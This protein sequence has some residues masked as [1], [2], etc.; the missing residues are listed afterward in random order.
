VVHVTV[1]VVLIFGEPPLPPEGESDFEWY[2]G[3]G[4]IVAGRYFHQDPPVWFLNVAD[5]PAVLPGVMVTAA[6]FYV[7]GLKFSTAIESYI[8]AW[9]WLL[10]G[11]CQWW[12]IGVF[13]TAARARRH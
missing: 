11:T 13:V 10:L 9:E 8:L 1:F 5:L 4:I 2:A 12:L 3:T 6:L 7:S